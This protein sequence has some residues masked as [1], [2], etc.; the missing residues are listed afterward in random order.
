MGKHKAKQWVSLVVAGGPGAVNEAADY[1]AAVDS[2]K[3][4]TGAI[5]LRDRARLRWCWGLFDED[6]GH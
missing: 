4:E 2:D 6:A 5:G 3:K 1:M